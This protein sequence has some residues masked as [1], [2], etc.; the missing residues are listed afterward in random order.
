MR[1]LVL[2]LFVVAV[3]ILA[4]SQWRPGTVEP[5]PPTP[6]M[7]P[8]PDDFTLIPPFTPAFACQLHNADVYDADLCRSEQIMETALAQGEGV[9]FI[10]HQST[11]STGCWGSISQTVREL[12]ICQLTSGAVQV[13]TPNLVTAFV[14]SPDGAWFAYG[15][16]NPLSID[17]DA[18]RPHIYRVSADG[19]NVQS[20]D[21]QAFPDFAVGAPA[22]LRWLDDTWIAVSLWDGTTGGWHSYRLKTDGS[23]VVEPLGENETQPS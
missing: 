22:D 23:G 20:L 19:A 12:R 1:Q 11:L 2:L 6:T 4:L 18:L 17:G 14:P 5:D 16:M 10:D 7:T 21:R 8:L 9:T 3:V 13:L 15:T